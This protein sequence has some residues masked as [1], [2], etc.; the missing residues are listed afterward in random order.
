M[1]ATP[2]DGLCRIAGA[3]S[4]TLRAAVQEANANTVADDIVLP[5]GTYR[6]SL[7]GAG[8][9]AGATGD[10]NVSTPIR[11]L[12]HNAMDTIIDGLSA[13]RIFAMDNS[14]RVAALTLNDVTLT[15]GSLVPVA[16]FGL[17]T[18]LRRI[19]VDSSTTG[20]R[21]PAALSTTSPAPRLARTR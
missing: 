16:P 6:L 5:A 1:D 13:D 14:T 3:A 19:A 11:I 12:G 2:G 8:E 18:S 15:H 17:S 20:P 7:T 9:L 21:E 10:L 4:C